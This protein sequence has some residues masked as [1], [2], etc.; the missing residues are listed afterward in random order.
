MPRIWPGC[1]AR[2]WRICDNMSWEIDGVDVSAKGPCFGL[3][4]TDA[5]GSAFAKARISEIRGIAEECPHL[6]F[7][8]VR[9]DARDPDLFCDTAGIA[10]TSGL[11]IV[12]ESHDA[13]NILRAASCLDGRAPLVRIVDGGLEDSAIVAAMLGTPLAVPGNDVQSLMDNAEL[14]ESMGADIVLDPSVT[15]MKGCLEMSTD[16]HRLWSDHGIPLAGH[17]LMVRAWSGEYA[18]AVASVSVMCHGDLVVLDNLDPEACRVLDAL[19]SSVNR[20][21]S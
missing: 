1:T 3:S 8:C 19:M 9:D 20:K 18:L 10:S 17:P 13:P 5:L 16:I 2:N 21:D 7:V 11:G 6:G 12:L 15:N 14:A 4:V